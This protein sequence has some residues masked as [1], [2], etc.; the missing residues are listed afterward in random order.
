MNT[1]TDWLALEKWAADQWPPEES[2]ALGHWRLR[3]SGGFTKRANSVLAVGDL[4]DDP[5]WYERIRRFYSDRGLPA[6][7]HISDSSPPELDLMLADKGGIVT[8]P[9]LGMRAPAAEMNARLR[10]YQDRTDV[11]A[12]LLAAP[13]PAWMEDYMLLEGHA[14]EARPFYEG[15]LERM[16]APKVFVRLMSDDGETVAL[17]TAHAS[18]GRAILSN[19]IV[20][21]NR[22]G[23]GFAK[24]L[25]AHLAAW[26][27]DS[28]ARSVFL[29]V[30]QDNAA[31]LHLYESA[32]F[33][34]EFKYHYRVLQ[35]G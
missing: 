33:Q 32:G 35:Q 23:Q 17:G 13:D 4:P 2:E 24:A 25:L 12:E 20:R 3:A 18:G 5:D 29:Q 34:P 26:C 14:E 8:A 9:C 7:F 21:E 15:L 19:I 10:P 16:P 22:R 11:A 27:A 28:G 30:L 31:A 6:V 1:K